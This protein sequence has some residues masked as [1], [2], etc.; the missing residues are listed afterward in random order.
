[1]IKIYQDFFNLYS[2]ESRRLSR[3]FN[4]LAF[5][6]LAAIVSFLINGWFCLNHFSGGFLAATVLSLLVFLILMKKQDSIRYR[7]DLTNALKEINRN[8]MEFLKTGK[9]SFENGASFLPEKHP[10]AGDLDLFGEFSLY[11]HLNRASTTMGKRRLAE[12]LLGDGSNTD[13]E[14]KQQAIKELM[15]ETNL[16]QLIQATG[17]LAK[18]SPEDFRRIVE[19]SSGV[20]SDLSLPARILSFAGPVVLSGLI[21]ASFISGAW[22]IPYAASTVYISNLM[23]LGTQMK[24]VK[25]EIS[26]ADKVDTILKNYSRIAVRIEEKSFQSPVLRNLQNVPGN[27]SV[28]ISHQLAKLSALFRGL[29]SI[30]NVLALF[31]LNG[32]MQYHVHALNALLKWK[33]NYAADLPLWLD[34]IGEAEALSS[35]ANFAANNTDYAFP[36]MMAEP[37]FSFSNLGHPLILREKRICNDVD[38]ADKR[39]V[40]LTG[41][42]MSGKSTFLRTL[43]LN[44]ILARTGAPVCASHARM[45][46]VDV[47]TSIQQSDSLNENESYFFAEVKRLKA[48]MDAAS[49]KPVFILLDEILRGTNSDDKRNGTMEVIR[50]LAAM[51][52]YGVIA[53][54]D[55]EIC[56]M[57]PDYPGVLSNMCFEA[58]IRDSELYFDY[59]LRGGVCRNKSATF[60]MKKMGII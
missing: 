2:R 33:K 3:I 29:E 30:S 1:M 35:L 28:T 53:T 17:M 16:R 38:F 26:G 45:F 23:M 7:L 57:E 18:D 54:H 34:R 31:I 10:N 24:R 44:L 52:C 19:W 48:I 4:W 46:P 22:W 49:G 5:F 8:E 14:A 47:L 36:E 37:G 39:F 15:P 59:K 6:R 43:G 9:S 42:N 40:I 51:N 41:S 21:V 55:L 13:I 27:G 32:L 60:L 56:N 50:K 11:H 12:K 58:E 25:N 20:T